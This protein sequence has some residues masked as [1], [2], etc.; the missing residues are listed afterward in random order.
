[1][2]YSDLWRFF[3]FYFISSVLLVVF[4]WNF[5]SGRR[6]TKGY[7]PDSFQKFFP[8][9]RLWSRFSRLLTL[10]LYIAA[11]WRWYLYRM[12]YV[13]Y[14]AVKKRIFLKFQLVRDICQFLRV[15]SRFFSLRASK[16]IAG[17]CFHYSA[18]FASF[19]IKNFIFLGRF[20]NTVLF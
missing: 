11:I 10:A 14:L 12:I 8:K 2:K 20:R 17:L 16:G 19:A 13:I 6:V 4:F 7:F 5:Y 18:R 1:M 3:P 9:S 15:D